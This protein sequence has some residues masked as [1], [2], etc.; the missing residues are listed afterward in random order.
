[1]LVDGIPSGLPEISNDT[2][3]EE[4]NFKVLGGHVHGYLN[5]DD[6]V[7]HEGDVALEVPMLIADYAVLRA[8]SSICQDGDCSVALCDAIYEAH[9]GKEA[10]KALWF[11]E[12]SVDRKLMVY[13][14]Y[15]VLGYG[16]K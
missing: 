15:R 14:G 13:R 9:D 10:V 2:V 7:R 1:M 12:V 5:G 8:L 16:R 6:L 3:G 4:I 11:V